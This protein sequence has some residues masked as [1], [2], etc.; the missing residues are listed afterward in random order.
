MFLSHEIEEGQQDL[1]Q[2]IGTLLEEVT[3]N[4]LPVSSFVSK[5]KKRVL[6]EPQLFSYFNNSESKKR[7]DLS[8]IFFGYIKDTNTNFSVYSDAQ[9]IIDLP[10]HGY[11]LTNTKRKK[12]K[13]WSVDGRI[14]VKNG[15]QKIQFK[16]EPITCIDK[17]NVEIRKHS[18]PF[19]EQLLRK[20]EKA[21]KQKLKSDFNVSIE[22]NIETYLPK[23]EDSFKLI[24]KVSPPQYKEILKLCRTIVLLKGTN[25]IAFTAL[26]MHGVV[27]LRPRKSDTRLF[28]AEH[29]IHE[30]SHI[31]LNS[32]LLNIQSFFTINPFEER[33]SSPF[34]KDLR[35][36]YQVIQAAFVLAKI[37]QFFSES[38]SKS[39]PKG[40]EFYETVGRIMLSLERLKEA[41][42]Y[43]D[44]KNIYTKKGLY[45]YDELSKLESSLR[46]K[47]ERFFEEYTMSNQKIEFDLQRFLKLN[48][49]I[50]RDEE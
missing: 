49:I 10:N 7:D 47:H 14:E 44:D 5:D 20:T 34:R 48:K 16:F 36:A 24:K 12:L 8:R 6:L 13:L 43:I 29:I 37:T 38:L 9:G 35:G 2:K 28:F 1:A 32:I 23:I 33:F 22:K 19:Y 27:F 4:R 17:T 46:H 11:L 15:E 45:I 30:V 42:R 21:G 39:K 41:L 25:L 26:E 31:A 40:K 18:H 3:K 50:H